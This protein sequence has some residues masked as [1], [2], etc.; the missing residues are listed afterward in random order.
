MI[1]NSGGGKEASKRVPLNEVH[2]STNR[3]RADVE[4]PEWLDGQVTIDV[5]R[6]RRLL[7]LGGI[8]HLRIE[9]VAPN[10]EHVMHGIAGFGVDGSAVAGQTVVREDSESLE[11]KEFAEVGSLFQN[12]SW[13]DI[14]T[15]V[16]LTKIKDR[17]TDRGGNLRNA[18]TWAIGV[19]NH[20]RSCVRRL[21][22]RHLLLEPQ[23]DF[24]VHLHRYLSVGNLGL[25]V[26]DLA[27]GNVPSGFWF[28]TVAINN[29]I[30]LS[31]NGP[32]DWEQGRG[33]RPNVFPS[34]EI[35]RATALQVLSRVQPIISAEGR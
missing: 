3:M 20:V 29:G 18:D 21:G 17:I 26:V 11:R 14:A 24:I 5:D 22:T 1:W 30:G 4:F 6:A 8:R 23:P 13:I 25:R 7:N 16:N 12:A 27:I 15:K 35:E 32:P 9:S 34:F 28:A 2:M 10:S 31:L 33:F 19:D